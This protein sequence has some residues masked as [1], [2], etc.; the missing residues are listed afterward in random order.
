MVRVRVRVR[1]Q[2]LRR[3]GTEGSTKK[4]PRKWLVSRR[5]LS[6]KANAW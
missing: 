3:D 5:R 1:E 2:S 6:W 4:T